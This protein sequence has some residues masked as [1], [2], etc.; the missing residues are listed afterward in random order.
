MHVVITTLSP[1]L[2]AQ[3]VRAS[4]P[5][6]WSN[7]EPVDPLYALALL[8][9]VPL[10]LFVLVTLAVYLPSLARGEHGGSGGAGSESAWFGGPRQGVDAADKVAADRL[11]GQDTGG[12]SG[13]W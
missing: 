5:E 12:A 1:Q 4:V 3:A 11:E 13:R 10:L 2:V 6:G 8:A 7:P 9:G